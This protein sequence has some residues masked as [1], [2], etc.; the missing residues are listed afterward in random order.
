MLRPPT[1][2]ALGLCLAVAVPV[3]A[4]D[5]CLAPSLDDPASSLSRTDHAVTG[6]RVA[7]GCGPLE[8]DEL[9]VA[10]GG[11][12]I[13]V[14]P[15]PSDRGSSWF[16]VLED[17]TVDHV[18]DDGRGGAFVSQSERPPLPAGDP[19]LA[20]Q[21]GEDEVVVGSALGAR[22]WFSDAL[23]DARVTEIPGAALVAPVGPTE[24]Y[25]HGVLGDAFEA[26][27]IEVRDQAGPL[28]GVAVELDEVVESTSAMV[29]ELASNEL[30]PELLVTVSDAAHG[31]RL[32][33][34]GLD[35]SIIAESDAIGQGY[36]WLHQIGAGS[37]APDGAL[38]VIAVRT[39]HIG[40]VV[41]A[42]R[43]VDGRFELAA[44]AAG[45]SSHQLGSANLDMALL[46]DADGDGRLDV[47]VPTEALDEIALLA[48]TSDGFDELGRLALGDRLRTN[49]AATPT[50]DGRLVIAAGTEAGT[51]RVFR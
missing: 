47:V 24:R 38:E 12:P 42:Y 25:E 37:L 29:V 2:A 4:A 32:R 41:E 11:T 23:P 21:T 6:N 45:Y 49:V 16:V 19:P 34:Y 5:E 22:G 51:L 35:G 33:A 17:G 31:A 28:A 8:G 48:R 10:L 30:G 46:A 50:A 18:V 13:W 14:L 27:A 39:P 7:G 44:S 26:A 9:E 43:L 3:A 40:G 15:D 1:L 20:L 36:R